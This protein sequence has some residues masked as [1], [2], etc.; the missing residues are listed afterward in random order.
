MINDDIELAH[1]ALAWDMIAIRIA[2]E[3]YQGYRLKR[4]LPPASLFAGLS[5]DA[6]ITRSLT[7]AIA[8]SRF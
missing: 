8:C 6:R 4:P 2:V 7:N 1:M 5:F 3:N